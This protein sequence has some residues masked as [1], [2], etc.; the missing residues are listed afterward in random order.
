MGDPVTVEGRRE[1]D[2]SIYLAI[3][4]LHDSMHERAIEMARDGD[5]ACSEVSV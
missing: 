2:D 3:Q 4:S 5:D 1:H